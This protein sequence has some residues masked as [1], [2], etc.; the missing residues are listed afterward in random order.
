MELFSNQSLCQKAS[1][2]IFYA[3]HSHI[4]F[5]FIFNHQARSII[6]FKPY[7][8]HTSFIFIFN[9]QANESHQSFISLL[10]FMP[11]INASSLFFLIFPIIQSTHQHTTTHQQITPHT[12]I[13]TST[14][15][16]TIL[17]TNTSTHKHSF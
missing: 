7:H 10:S 6:S 3:S 15:I 8:P 4:I 11:V 1:S 16:Y 2:A 17:K 9:Q 13:Q 12:S 5:I 14:L